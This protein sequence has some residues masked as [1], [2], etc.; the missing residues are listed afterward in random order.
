[1]SC[2]RT[3]TQW[4][5]WGSNPSV[6]SQALSTTE[7]LCSLGPLCRFEPPSRNSGSALLLVQGQIHDFWEGG[8]R[9]IKRGSACWF[10]I[11]FLKYPH[12]NEI[13]SFQ[14]DGSRETPEPPLDLPPLCHLLITIAS[15]LDPNRA[16]QNVGH[17]LHLNLLKLPLQTVWTKIRPDKMSGLIWVQTV[18]HS[19]TDGITNLGFNPSSATY[20]L[21]QTI[22]SN[23]AAFSKITNK[24]WYFMEDSH[25][26]SYLIFL[27]IWKDVAKFV[28]CCS[29]DWCFKG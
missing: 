15:S 4:R 18:W 6:S 19:V 25:E 29:C 7:P 12:E 22:I 14:M 21:Q 20:N 8:I 5:R 17:D 27:K 23:F 16:Q 10:Y 26:T 13:I 11:I 1:M 24:E 3:T 2:S 9:R 28:V